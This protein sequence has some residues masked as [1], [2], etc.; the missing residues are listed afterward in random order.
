MLIVPLLHFSEETQQKT[1]LI[2]NILIFSCYQFLIK[3]PFLCEI[4]VKS[5]NFLQQKYERLN[6][7]LFSVVPLL[8]QAI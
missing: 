3:N 7:V 1:P 2:N 4:I 8:L 6:I 5:V